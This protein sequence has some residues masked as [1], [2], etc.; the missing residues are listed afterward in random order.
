[1][2]LKNYAKNT[3]ANERLEFAVPQGTQ[4][5]QF[6]FRYTGTN[7]AFW[8]VDRVTFQQ[9]QPTAPAAPQ[10]LRVTSD[11]AT[12]TA[13]WQAP[14]SDGHSPITAYTVTATPIVDKGR[15]KQA[16]P[17]SVQ[18]TTLTATLN[19]L[20]NGVSYAVTVTATNAYGTSVT[21][22]AVLT[23]PTVSRATPATPPP[24]PKKG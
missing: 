23:T 4:Q 14:A 2:S 6:R 3:N 9:A 15:S 16:T 7:S 17:V 20:R 21:S 19:G 8:T 11:D 22:D 10:G 5:A 1:M 12:A 13:S 18:T 24:K